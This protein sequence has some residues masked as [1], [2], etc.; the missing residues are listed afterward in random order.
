MKLPI[1][2]LF[3]AAVYAGSHST[4][5]LLERVQGVRIANRIPCDGAANPQEELVLDTNF[6]PG[7]W[8]RAFHLDV[9]ESQYCK[10]L[11]L[12]FFCLSH[13]KDRWRHEWSA[14]SQSAPGEGHGR[15]WINSCAASES[16]DAPEYLLS[17]WYREGSDKKAQWKQAAVKKVSETPEVY[18]FTDPHGGTALLEIKRR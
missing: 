1:L 6:S 9:F 15:F 17:G 2:A 4:A 3:C 14:D 13:G 10:R 16:K 7:E 8:Q 12:Y 5:D 18:E 11:D